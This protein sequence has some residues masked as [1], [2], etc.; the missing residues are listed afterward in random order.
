MTN[1]WILKSGAPVAISRI[2]WPPHFTPYWRRAAVLLSTDK[3]LYQPDQTL[4]MRAIV[5]DDQRH[6]WAKHPLRFVIHDPDEA[7]IFRGNPYSENKVVQKRL[8]PI[9]DALSIPRC[10]MHAFRHGHGSLMHSSGASLK[11]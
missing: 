3:P 7:V 2:P 10:G 4:H 8:W 5:L 1:K 9:L 6:A 11:V